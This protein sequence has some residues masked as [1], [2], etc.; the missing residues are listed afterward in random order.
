M[1]TAVAIILFIAIVV[2]LTRDSLASI[3]MLLLAGVVSQNVNGLVTGYW[4][5]RFSVRAT[6]PAAPLQSKSECQ[7]RVWCWRLFGER[8]PF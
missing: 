4:F 1:F 8:E 7:I 2:A 5:A 3:G 6:L